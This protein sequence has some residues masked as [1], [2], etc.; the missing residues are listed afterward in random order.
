MMA[1]LTEDGLPQR[2][3]LYHT[4]DGGAER[5]SII[6]LKEGVDASDVAQSLYDD[7][8]ND[9]DTRDGGY[10][11][12]T[13]AL[14]RSES[15]SEPE[16]QFPF[17]VQP[18]IGRA[19][20]GGDTEQPTEKGERAQ[21]MRM[22]NDMHN[23]MM[24]YAATLGGQMSA[25]L[26]KV[27][28]ERALLEDKLRKQAAEFEDLQDRRLD[29]ELVRAERI[30]RDKI[31][32]DVASALLPVIPIFVG[33][34]LGGVMKDKNGHESPVAKALVPADAEARSRETILK[35]LFA[36]MSDPEKQG[37]FS[38]LK[39]MHRITLFEV[40][41][42]AEQISDD[43][44]RATFDKAMQKFLKSLSTEEV[45]GILDALD[46][47]NRNRFM[48]VYRSYGE[49]ETAEQEDLPEIMRDSAAPPPTPNDE[50]S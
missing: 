19:W 49:K 37:L 22:V 24:K 9:M 30:A 13:V 20:S 6:R 28:T 40:A 50:A 36:N 11:R 46:Q 39:P 8:R 17:R 31:F 12:Y 16:V 33:K 1:D 48:V 27:R 44:T 38:A 3:E 7:A 18:R 47:G 32:T 10:Q 42:A 2:F 34:M 21:N 29:R 23:M 26:D 4:V 25:E 15:Q 43:M 5:L 41:K 45:M 35:E 14:F